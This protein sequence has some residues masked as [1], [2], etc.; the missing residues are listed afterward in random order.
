MVE[1]VIVLTVVG[2]LAGLIIPSIL[3]ARTQAAATQCLDNCRAL[4]EAFLQYSQD[5]E[6][7]LV[8]FSQPRPGK[9]KKKSSGKLLWTELLGK[10]SDEH[11][12]WHC[13]ECR[14]GTHGG[15]AYNR[16]LASRGITIGQVL[17]PAQTVVIGDAGP[18]ANSDETNPDLWREDVSSKMD[19]STRARFAVP[20]APSWKPSKQAPVR[21]INRHRGRAS[22]I[23]ADGNAGRLPVSH[24]GFQHEAGDARA[25]W[26]NQ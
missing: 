7:R 1:L 21:M 15:L 24:I 26:D 13:P 20:T 6:G 5:N 22:T 2:L 19:N 3:K 23:F 17:K 14:T 4:G 10:Y 16:L 12:P 8:P 9:V 18:V 25:L 11:Q